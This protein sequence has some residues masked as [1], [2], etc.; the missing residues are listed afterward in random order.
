MNHRIRLAMQDDDGGTLDGEVEVDETYIGGKARNMNRQQ[1]QKHLAG[2]GHKNAWAGKVAVLG[3]L[4]RHAEKGKSRIR[5]KPIDTIRTYRLHQ[6]V[7]DNVQDG[8][9]YY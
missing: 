7:T 1:R 4:Q 8:A 3:L 6:E 5:T 2:R 9:T